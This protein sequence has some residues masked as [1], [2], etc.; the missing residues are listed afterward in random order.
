MSRTRACNVVGLSGYQMETPFAP[1]LFV[2]I[3][4]RMGQAVFEV[5][6]GAINNALESAN[7]KKQPGHRSAAEPKKSE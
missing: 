4:K 6:H 2:A 1:S 7:A 3:R 5:F